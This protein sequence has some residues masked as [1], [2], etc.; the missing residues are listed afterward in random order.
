MISLMMHY[1]L[2][3]IQDVFVSRCILDCSHA[4]WSKLA[5]TESGVFLYTHR[6]IFGQML[7]SAYEKWTSFRCVCLGRRSNFGCH[8]ADGTAWRDRNRKLD[9]KHEVYDR[10]I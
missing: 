5:K 10:C 2:P 7:I 1:Y 8:Q 9:T 6:S 4:S 3:T